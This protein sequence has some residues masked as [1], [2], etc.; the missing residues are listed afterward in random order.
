MSCVSVSVYVCAHVL[1]V[2]LCCA[3]CL[4]PKW[5]TSQLAQQSHAYL[6]GI[7]AQ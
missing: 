1:V 3:C 6:G 2:F 5:V 7:R 4:W